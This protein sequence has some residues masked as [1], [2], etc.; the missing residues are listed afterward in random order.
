MK[1]PKSNEYSSP[2]GTRENN[3]KKMA[4]KNYESP[5]MDEVKVNVE[6]DF[7]T[8]STCT[9]DAQAGTGTGTCDPGGE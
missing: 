5:K 2:E 4:K 8:G 3:L 9:A 1:F 6:Q 7:L